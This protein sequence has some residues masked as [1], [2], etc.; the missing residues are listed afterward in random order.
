MYVVGG[1]R[2]RLFM[3]WDLSLPASTQNHTSCEQYGD[4]N[5]DCHRQGTEVQNS[6]SQLDPAPQLYSCYFQKHD[7]NSVP[8]FN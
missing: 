6:W 1:I 4:S 7:N 2:I 8:K 3:P 5:L